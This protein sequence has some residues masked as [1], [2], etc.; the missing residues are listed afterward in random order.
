MSQITVHVYRHCCCN[1]NRKLPKNSII[2]FLKLKGKSD[3]TAE[4]KQIEGR[5]SM[6]NCDI[7]FP[8]FSETIHAV[9]KIFS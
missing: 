5:T 8:F 3:E 9:L 4:R 7:Y 2:R 6:L 1:F